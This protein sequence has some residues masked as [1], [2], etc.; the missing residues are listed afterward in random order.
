MLA[1]AKHAAENGKVGLSIVL[2]AVWCFPYINNWNIADTLLIAA[3]NFGLVHVGRL[4]WSTWAHHSSASISKLPLWSFFRECSSSSSLIRIIPHLHYISEHST[5]PN[6]SINC[7]P[8]RYVDFVFG[9]ETEAKTFSKVQG[10][11]VKSVFWFCISVHCTGNN[12]E[13]SI[14]VVWFELLS[15]LCC[16]MIGLG[17][18]YLD[19]PV[20]S[21]AEADV[22]YPRCSI[23]DWRH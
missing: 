5:P 22:A 8:F 17:W 21:N 20:T 14:L 11:E 10:W 18:D 15:L 9:N 19:F 16:F 12:M 13:R 1:V 7:V 3:H 23:S 6:R 2:N 4:T